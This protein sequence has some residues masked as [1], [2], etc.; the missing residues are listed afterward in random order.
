MSEHH[1]QHHELSYKEPILV[2]LG[3]VVLTILTVG[4]AGLNVSATVSL[5][6]AFTIASVKSTF[7]VRYFMHLKYEDR[8]FT[9]FLGCAL[10]TFAVVFILMF[11]DYSFRW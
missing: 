4:L 1:E 11:S 5:L 6:I 9:I 3:L 8:L 2:F 10:G 7:V